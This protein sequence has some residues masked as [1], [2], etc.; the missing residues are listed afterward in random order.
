MGEDIIG[1]AHSSAMAMM[2]CSSSRMH[3]HARQAHI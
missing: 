3:C 1:M 2:M